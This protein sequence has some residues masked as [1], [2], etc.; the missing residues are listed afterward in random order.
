MDKWPRLALELR[1]K[2]WSDGSVVRERASEREG[3]GA[4]TSL[5]GFRMQLLVVNLAVKFVV[6][7]ASQTLRQMR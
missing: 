1:S 6:R 4:G 3:A 2:G 5:F 7:Q